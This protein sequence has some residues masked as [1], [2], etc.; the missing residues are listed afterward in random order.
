MLMTLFALLTP[1]LVDA[2]KPL[3]GVLGTCR[4]AEVLAE[5]YATLPP[6]NF[7]QAILEHT[8]RLAVLPM[9]GVYW[10]N[11]GDPRR[12]LLDLARCGHQAPVPRE[13]GTARDT[14]TG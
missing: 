3:R 4:E 8:P 6:V 13:Q 11:W 7:S 9:E 12:L 5:V 2:F 1:A 10:S 14:T